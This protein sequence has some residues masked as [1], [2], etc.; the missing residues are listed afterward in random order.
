MFSHMLYENITYGSNII[1]NNI[2][3]K[4]KSSKICH[5]WDHA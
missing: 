1:F 2:K 5:L 4:L 3:A